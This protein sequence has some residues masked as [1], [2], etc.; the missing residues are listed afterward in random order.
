VLKGLK[1]VPFESDLI[2][3][4]K[5]VEE[6]NASFNGRKGVGSLCLMDS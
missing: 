5:I 4:N 6:V 3:L 2:N 1:L